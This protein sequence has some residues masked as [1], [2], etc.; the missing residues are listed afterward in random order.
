[1][2]VKPFYDSKPTIIN[3]PLM[4]Y[5]TENRASLQ[6]LPAINSGKNSGYHC[7]KLRKRK[8]HNYKLFRNYLSGLARALSTI[9]AGR[10]R[11]VEQIFIKKLTKNSK[12]WC[13]TYLIEN[14]SEETIFGIKEQH[15]T[16]EF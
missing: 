16:M 12:Y 2:S 3:L 9:R 4:V 13:H 14:P 11:G 8:V 7:W 6:E 10:A 15:E 1:M 5:I